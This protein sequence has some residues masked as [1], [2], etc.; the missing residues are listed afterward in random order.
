MVKLGS[1]IGVNSIY[2]S[3]L[4]KGTILRLLVLI[5][6][7]NEYIHLPKYAVR[8]REKVL[9]HWSEHT[10]E[11]AHVRCEQKSDLPRQLVNKKTYFE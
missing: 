7:R 9:V 3:F 1:V 2:G 5:V 6:L 11:F 8:K 10:Q 4:V